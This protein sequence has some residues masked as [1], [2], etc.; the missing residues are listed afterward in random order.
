MSANL[1]KIKAMFGQTKEQLDQQLLNQTISIE[2][3]LKREPEVLRNLN[4]LTS[5]RSVQKIDMQS[6]FMNFKNIKRKY[7][8][9]MNSERPDR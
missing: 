5:L 8:D 2:E 9:R 1:T 4:L 3:L 6:R 7:G